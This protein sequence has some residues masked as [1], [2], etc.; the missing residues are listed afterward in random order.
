MQLRVSAY[1][2]VVRGDEVLLAHWNESGRHGW[3]LP[4]G[5]IDPGEHPAD[6]AV[7][8]VREESGYTVALVG[9]LGVDSIVVP[10]GQT[11]R[12][13]GPLHA[14]RVV[15]RAELVCGELTPEIDGSTDE[16]RWFPLAEVTDLPRVD[17]V[18]VGLRMA[19]LLEAG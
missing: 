15:Y 5:G 13:A 2:V 3:T 4:G 10:A 7:R 18:D 14:V 19:G 8:E 1:A 16:A 6:A 17:L 12:I 9:L 11:T